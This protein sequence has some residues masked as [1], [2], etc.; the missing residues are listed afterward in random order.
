MRESETQ[1]ECL[2]WGF[3]KGA[4]WL[5]VCDAEVQVSC[6]KMENLKNYISTCGRVTMSEFIQQH[7]VAETKDT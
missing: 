7:I 2:V 3:E 5:G 6:G 4:N 1:V